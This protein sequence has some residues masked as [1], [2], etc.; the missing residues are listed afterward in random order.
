MEVHL[1]GVALPDLD[2]RVP[3]RAAGRV[4]HAAGQV[5]DLADGRRDVVV[6]DDQVV[7]GVER[8]LV[9]VERP[10]LRWPVSAASCSAN[11]PRVVKKAAPAVMVPRKARRSGRRSGSW[12]GPFVFGTGGSRHVT[13]VM[14]DQG[15]GAFPREE[16][17]HAACRR[18]R[19][20]NL[21]IKGPA[22]HDGSG[23]GSCPTSRECLT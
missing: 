1:V 16:T 2:G 12:R 18:Q 3:H 6:D 10:L 22:R 14:A 17:R 7:V 11:S 4:Q 5:R 13:T 21:S 9:R 23:R 15:A 8:Q 19:R 20:A